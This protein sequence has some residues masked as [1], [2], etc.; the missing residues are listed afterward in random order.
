MGLVVG[1]DSWRLAGEWR[2]GGRLR[3]FCRVIFL[4]FQEDAREGGDAALV[5]LR[6]VFFAAYR[7]GGGG[8]PGQ[9][10][11]HQK[12]VCLF[13]FACAVEKENVISH[14]VQEGT[15]GGKK[16]NAKPH[17]A[18][19]PS[20]LPFCLPGYVYRA[21]LFVFCVRGEVGANVATALRKE[22]C[23]TTMGNDGRS[24]SGSPSAK[25]CN[26]RTHA[27][28]LAIKDLRHML[29]LELLA[30]REAVDHGQSLCGF[31]VCQKH[32]NSRKRTLTGAV[33][34]TSCLPPLIVMKVKSLFA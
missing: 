23:E 15:C 32:N 33:S 18:P 16:V 17:Q 19:P 8:C 21:C 13:F 24:K 26:K 10:C 9:T 5:S 28:R 22:S 14:L 7:R 1:G 34:G 4:S 2:G 20:T 31:C 25:V 12:F 6:E 3:L 11:N 27:A 29:H 30:A